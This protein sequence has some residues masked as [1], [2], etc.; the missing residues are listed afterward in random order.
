MGHRIDS[1]MVEGLDI[2]TFD[3]EGFHWF[4]EDQKTPLRERSA[5]LDALTHEQLVPKSP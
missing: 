5:K 4:N 3:G 1:L 2:A